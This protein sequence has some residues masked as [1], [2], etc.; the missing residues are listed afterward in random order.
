VARQKLLDF[1]FNN[2][3]VRCQ[4]LFFDMTMC[5]QLAG[6]QHFS[7]RQTL[8]TSG[9][10]KVL[11]HVSDLD[12]LLLSLSK[13]TRQQIRRSLKLLEQSGPVQLDF[14]NGSEQI[15]RAANTIAK[16]HIN[17]WQDS[18]WGSGFNNPYFVSF[19][20]HLMQ[21]KQAEILELRHNDKALAYGYYFCFNKRV[22]F[23]LSAMTKHEN[24]QIKIGLVMHILAMLKFAELGYDEYDFLAGDARYK[25]SLSDS[26]YDMVSYCL[27]KNNW[28][29]KTERF[30][31]TLKQ[32]IT[33][34]VEQQS[35]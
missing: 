3:Q 30:F 14:I 27:D 1:L 17:Q 23:Y 18:E 26:S 34:K 5:T 33:N 19:H 15:V 4:R 12:S 7:S 22:L 13:N 21:T 16:L 24:N 8:V 2:N 11:S 28:L 31:R 6:G 9:Y 20:Q 29:G 25:R 32:K 35:G 10:K